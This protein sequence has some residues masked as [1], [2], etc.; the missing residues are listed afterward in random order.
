MLFSLATLFGR[1][2]PYCH[3]DGLPSADFMHMIELMELNKKTEQL[4]QRVKALEET[5]SRDQSYHLDREYLS[6]LTEMRKRFDARQHATEVV[7]VHLYRRNIETESRLN[8]VSERN[9][10]FEQ[11]LKELLQDIEGLEERRRERSSIPQETPSLSPNPEVE[12]PSTDSTESDSNEN[13]DEVDEMQSVRFTPLPTRLT[14]KALDSLESSYLDANKSMIEQW[15]EAIRKDEELRRSSSRSA[16]DGV[17]DI[18][19]AT[20]YDN[21]PSYWS[22]YNY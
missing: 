21:R 17:E 14:S 7:L 8:T 1:L 19:V 3:H 20:P 11:Q 22:R 13:N 16:W 10:A 6:D 12:G 18:E 5:N 4:D 2:F 15:T 9:A